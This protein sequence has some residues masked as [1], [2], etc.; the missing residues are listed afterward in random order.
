M[1][2]PFLAQLKQYNSS[3]FRGDL[4]GALTVTVMLVPQGLAYAMLAGLP[5][6]YGLYAA[7][8]PMMIYPLFGSSRNLSVGPVA[9][10]S[11]IVL[12]GLSKLATPMSAEYIQLAML[13]SLVAG[14][15]QL[16]LSL[17]RMG[18]LVNFL[19]RP[20]ISGF[21]SAA[22][23]IISVSQLKHIFGIDIPRRNNIMVSLKDLCL[24]MD[25][26][27][28]HAL[29]LGVAGLTVILIVK[30]I[31]KKIPGALIA[32]LLG[33]GMVF[34][35][36]WQGSVSLV[37]EVPKGLPSFEIPI[38][39]WESI[40]KVTPLAL[41]IC[42][43]SFIE[44]LAI[45]KTLSAKN[46][47]YPI[48]GNKEL[49]GLGLAKIIGAFF[50]AFPNTGSFSRSAINEQAGAKTGMSSIIAGV[51]ILLTLLFFTPLFYNLPNPILAAIVISA[52][53]GLIEFKEA[54]RLFHHDRKDFV[55]L[56]ATFLLTLLL[57]VQQGV[58]VGIAISLMFIIYKVSKPHYAVLG[59]IP[60]KG[61]YR[62]IDRFD[63]AVT[64]PEFLI[65][66]YDDDIFFGN[67]IHFYEAVL[68]ELDG[69]PTVKNFILDAS[70]IST[71][72]ST[73]VHQLI[74][75]KE[76]LDKRE[77]NFLFA[78]LKGPMRDLFEKYKLNKYFP[79]DQMFLDIDAAR[80]SSYFD[81]TRASSFRS[82]IPIL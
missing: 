41:V 55:V 28:W 46:G 17:L 77:I 47:N 31:H 23:I 56:M 51:M 2:N 24:S 68:K 8:I 1:N 60:G 61:V 82:N 62:N 20:V 52:V 5:P 34:A 13:T 15:I 10:V 76:V 72:D 33:I 27:N 75:L 42:L 16:A 7:L 78:G 53:F 80:A 70:S 36:N 45:A 30:K 18:F 49:L 69:D 29:L 32:V 43:I 26:V 48:D 57:G 14:V 22:A 11:I 66:R 25:T 73:A 65:F 63:N 19:S 54:K 74:L 38:F 12:S 67:A 81:L 39:S 6:I 40:M 71:M 37:G 59:N 35:F 3:D 79:K 50:Q 58:F 4:I 21:T 64:G 44:S 9:L